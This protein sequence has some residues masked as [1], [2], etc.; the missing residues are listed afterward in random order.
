[1]KPPPP[2]T[3]IRAV[4][5]MLAPSALRFPAVQATSRCRYKQCVGRLVVFTDRRCRGSVCNVTRSELERLTIEFNRCCTSQIAQRAAGS[6]C[7]SVL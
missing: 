6:D 1:M 3:R 2:V 5:A 4:S 7:G